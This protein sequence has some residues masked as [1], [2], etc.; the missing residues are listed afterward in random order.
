LEETTFAAE[1][2]KERQDLQ[3]LIRND[4]TIL[5]ADLKVVAEDSADALD[6]DHRDLRR[7]DIQGEI[8]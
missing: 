8:Y 6:E 3:R 5:G 1:K 2:V 7:E 4:V